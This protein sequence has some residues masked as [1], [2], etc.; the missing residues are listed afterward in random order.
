MQNTP[1]LIQPTQVKPTYLPQ[2]TMGIQCTGLFGR[3]YQVDDAGS[4]QP[5]L[6]SYHAISVSLGG[7]WCQTKIDDMYYEEVSR[8]GDLCLMPSGSTVNFCWDG[9]G[10]SLVFL[11]D[12]QFLQQV[13]TA[14]NRPNPNQLELR[15]VVYDRPAALIS[16]AQMF[17]SEMQ[18]KY[19][20]DL[21]LESLAQVFAIQVLREYGVFSS[22]IQVTD[23]QTGLSPRQLQCTIDYVE[24]HL[25]EK[26][27][28]A[29]IAEVTGFNAA[30]F[31]ILFKKSLGLTPFQYILQQRT[32]R[33]KLL[34]KQS[35][36]E[37]VDIALQCGFANQSHFTQSFSQV[38]GTT[39]K[40]YQRQAA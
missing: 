35:Q 38:V 29:T 14:T 26:L 8:P 13:A 21:Y 24:C 28:L 4:A 15:P 36:L 18:Q 27:K 32:E 16:L 25:H 11:L 40:A 23:P 5:P 31:C 3:H 20:T 37:I 19:L 17:Q 6:T 34:L 7:A 10:S 12:P 9:P 33:A 22:Q 1:K 30:Y 2:P 39:P